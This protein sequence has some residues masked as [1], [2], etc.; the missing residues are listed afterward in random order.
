MHCDAIANLGNIFKFATGRKSIMEKINIDAS[1]STPIYKQIVNDIRSRVADGTL[2]S[3]A[4]ILLSNVF[5]KMRAGITA[6]LDE[7]TK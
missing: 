6:A 5:G 7:H 1:A 2:K 3:G 4:K